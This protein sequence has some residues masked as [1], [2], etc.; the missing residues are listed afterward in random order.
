ML[1]LQHIDCITKERT[2]DRYRLSM[3]TNMTTRQLGEGDVHYG[4][5]EIYQEYILSSYHS[6]MSLIPRN[7]PI[8]MY[9]SQLIT[10]KF[11]R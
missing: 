7:V 4:G 9:N 5:K 3:V 11:D 2:G 6:F 8:D 10:R 1:L